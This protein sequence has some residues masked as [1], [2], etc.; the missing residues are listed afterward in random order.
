MIAERILHEAQA[1]RL[2]AN[3]YVR[4]NH[5]LIAGG[6]WME[7]HPVFAKGDRSPVA[8]GRDMSDGDEWHDDSTESHA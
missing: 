6:A 4:L 8:I 5:S 3:L 2:R 1:P 7:H